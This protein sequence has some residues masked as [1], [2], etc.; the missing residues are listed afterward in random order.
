MIIRC[1]IKNKKV[2]GKIL[3]LSEINKKLAYDQ[4]YKDYYYLPN[5]DTI[6]P[7]SLGSGIDKKH[8]KAATKDTCYT[9]FN[10]SE[11]FLQN[12]Q[13]QKQYLEHALPYFLKALK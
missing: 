9:W 8:R 7:K 11:Q 13:M 4:N 3:M 10:C 1:I 6:I 2:E 12:P 5:E